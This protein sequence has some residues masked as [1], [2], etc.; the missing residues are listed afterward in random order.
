MTAINYKELTDEAKQ[1]DCVNFLNRK[2]P[3]RKPKSKYYGIALEDFDDLE[4][5]DLSALSK[6][7][8]I[9]LLCKDQD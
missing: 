3:L 2:Y 7:A 1:I 8:K 5:Y 9:R 4:G 6:Q